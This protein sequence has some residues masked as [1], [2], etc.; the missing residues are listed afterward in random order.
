MNLKKNT[1]NEN[2]DL[3]L[4]EK[5]TIEDPYY[6]FEFINDLTGVKYYQVFT[7]VSIPGPQRER[8]NL[9]NIEVVNSGA[10][11]NQ[12]ILGNIGTYEYNIYEQSS[13]T[14]LDPAL[15]GDIVEEGIMKLTDDTDAEGIYIEHEPDI[16]YVA[17]EQ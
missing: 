5:T 2:V 15:A 6:L 10:G 7:D 16:T 8:S 1:V 9:F 12:I 13:P 4:V 3:T 17:H 11:A 14:N